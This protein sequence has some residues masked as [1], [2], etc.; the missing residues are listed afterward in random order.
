MRNLTR[1]F[2][3]AAAVTVSAHAQQFT[4]PSASQ[5]PIATATSPNWTL[6]SLLSTGDTVPGLTGGSSYVMGG[7]PDGL[8]AYDNG[9]GT[10]T[11]LSNHELYDTW[12]VAVH[13][14]SKGAY[15]SKYIINK[16]TLQ[17]VSGG[18]FLTSNAYLYLWNQATT[19]WA[20]GNNYAMWRLCSA[21]L[22]PVSALYNSVSTNGYNGRIFLNGEEGAAS[23][24]ANN[25][26]GS[27]GFAWIATGAEAGRV[28]E[29]PHLGRYAIENLLANP[30]LPTTTDK[31]IVAGNND[32]SPQGQVY[33]YIGT[34]QST[35]NAIEKA[36]LTN[37]I[38]YGVKVT[39]ATGYTGAV[40]AELATGLNGNFTLVSKTDGT[41]TGATPIW[42]TSTTASGLTTNANAAGITG[43]AR[44]EDG[45]WLNA[46]TYLFNTTGSTPSGATTQTAAKVYKLSFS[47]AADY[48][49]GGTI[50]VLV[51]SA[52][53]KGKDGTTAWM[54]DNIAVGRDGLVYVNEDPGANQ[55]VA[56]TWVVDPTAAD[57]TA[58]ALQ[59]ME[60]DR[61]RFLGT[62]NTTITSGVSGGNTIVVAS[63]AGLAVG[64]AIGGK[65]IPDNT[66]IL[67]VNSATNTVTLSANLTAASSGLLSAGAD[68]R[69]WDEEFTGIVDVSDIWND[70]TKYFLVAIQDHKLS[71]ADTSTYTVEG[72]QFILMHNVASVAA[73]SNGVYNMNGATLSATGGTISAPILL[74]GTG[75]VFDMTGVNTI[76]SAIGGS[77]QL[78]KLGAGELILSAANTHVG[79]TNVSAGTLTVNG[80]ILSPTTNVYYGATLKGSG[81]IRGDVRNYG[82]V[83]P[84]N[85]PGTLT[86]TGNYTE[87]GVLAIEIAGVD[88]AGSAT[89]HDQLVVGGTFNAMGA[90]TAPASAGST[91][92]LIKYAGFDPL[93]TQSFKVISAANYAGGFAVLDRSSQTTQLLYQPTTGTVYGTGLTE[94][95]TFADLD[96]TVAN[97]VAVGAA[98]WADG[99]TTG[100]VIKN[101]AGTTTTAA[102]KAYLA[103]TDVGNAAAAVLLAA[104]V[105]AAL[106]ALSPEAYG[107]VAAMGARNSLALARGFFAVAP[108][109]DAWTYQL[110][111]DAQKAT[112]TASPTTLNGTYDVNASYVLATRGLGASG[113]VSLL[114]STDHGNASA[115]G[116]ASKMTG[117]T[118]GL[119]FGADFGGAR[120]DLGFTSGVEKVSGVR[121]GQT[122]NSAKLGAST[123]LARLTAAPVAGF[124]PFVGVSRSTGSMDAVAEVGTGANLNV[125]AFSQETTLA[126]VGA[127]FA[128][129]L[130]DKLTL[131]LSAAYERDL[132]SA[133]NAITAGFADAS[134]PT[135]FTVNT[136]GFGKDLF[137]GGV[138]L[139]AALSETSSAGISYEMRSGTGVKSASEL[140]LSY[141]SRF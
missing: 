131:G 66:R 101:G 31:T 39:S 42:T 68:F 106:D 133:N 86:V 37:G 2:L 82:T 27:R 100:T 55:Y 25:P 34:K 87:N 128:Y 111:Y 79:N 130:N 112:S 105:G 63:V 50:S 4:G 22:A 21:D 84:G 65:G 74:S 19:S 108:V 7:I 53:L 117:Q 102:T 132:G 1:S 94:A 58:S 38:L 85:S 30:F 59:V 20:S 64:Q 91:L 77:G 12:G 122:F 116:F 96:A 46:T 17:V 47:N 141:T 54:F 109:G 69:T 135:S 73:L 72:G 126:E 41:N 115:A 129:R 56:K 13:A 114:L 113:K 125:G 119:G 26:L 92:A 67:A 138:S 89:G 110:G 139:K 5:T 29:L 137:R 121:S 81:T 3:L 15:V 98:L 43:F 136:Y 8:G 120:L 70:G 124:S 44:P 140:K 45:A 49:A 48:T 76:S 57:P 88:G 103:A 123:F 36:G 127:D 28:Y 107:A 104:D 16:T 118:F 97:R 80:S 83:A 24:V 40:A 60:V 134:A 71:G 9:D 23:S 99:V 14:G 75:G 33:I 6:T 32:T 62:V 93:R 52:R 10:F 11:L 90:A 95:Q 51:D 61:S 18:D 78:W 35:G